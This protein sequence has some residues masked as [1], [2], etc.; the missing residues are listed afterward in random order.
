MASNNIF[1][2]KSQNNDFLSLMY[3]KKEYSNKV[4]EKKKEEEK[5]KK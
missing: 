2:F 1:S 3:Q 5:K 4:A